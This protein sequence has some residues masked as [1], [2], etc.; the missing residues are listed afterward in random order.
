MFSVRDLISVEDLGL[1]VV[2]ATAEGIDE[3]VTGAFI[4]D[5]PKPGAFLYAGAIVLTSGLWTRN[6][7]DVVSFMNARGP[8]AQRCSV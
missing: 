8:R 5:L 3:P 1:S 4:T 7:G 2:A 6:H